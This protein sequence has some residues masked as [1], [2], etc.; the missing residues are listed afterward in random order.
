ERQATNL[1]TRSAAFAKVG[2][3]L[4]S[5]L[6]L[7][8][9]G[10]D[11]ARADV[12][13]RTADLASAREAF[14]QTLELQDD[15]N[16][17]ARAPVA[18][19]EDSLPHEDRLGRLDTPAELSQAPDLRLLAFRQQLAQEMV[20]TAKAGRF[21]TV[22]LRGQYSNYGPKRFDNYPDELR[23]GID[24]RLTLFDGM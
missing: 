23:V 24:A 6:A 22:A 5:D 19:V 12:E 18:L 11:S 20:K 13:A 7:V 9:L 10:A 2:R 17:A 4:P 16:A 3:A 8:R 1:D 15:G 21:P 14:M